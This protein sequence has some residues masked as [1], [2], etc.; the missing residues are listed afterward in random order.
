MN[1]LQRDCSL[2]QAFSNYTFDGVG[3][4]SAHPLIQRQLGI[5]SC[6]KILHE[7]PG[8]GHLDGDST[9]IDNLVTTARRDDD[10]I[11]EPLLVVI[12]RKG[13]VLKILRRNEV[14]FVVQDV[15]KRL[16]PCAPSSFV[17]W[18][19]KGPCGPVSRCHRR[20]HSTSTAESRVG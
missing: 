17:L 15:T 16:A 18:R 5:Q 7:Q 13:C 10:A 8:P 19:R 3:F 20:Q 4:S 2:F 9:V 11:A 6:W 12:D 14:G 1:A